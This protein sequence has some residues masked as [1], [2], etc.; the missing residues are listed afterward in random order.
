MICVIES[1]LLSTSVSFVNTLKPVIAVFSG[2]VSVSLDTVGASFTGVT[3]M[4]NVAVS[5]PPLAS[6]AV[7]VMVGTG[8]L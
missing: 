3:A 8:P 5:V 7:Y 2:V 6:T 4:F 1:V